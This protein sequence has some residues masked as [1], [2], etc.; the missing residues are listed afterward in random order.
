VIGTLE[1]DWRS[2][3]N[4][5]S[6]IGNWAADAMRAFAE[7]DIAFANSGGFRKDLPAGKITVRDVWEIFPFNNSFV[8]FRVSGKM[9][10]AMISW[11]ADGKGELMQVSGV[12][13]TFDSSKPP[14]QKVVSIEVNANPVDDDKIYSVVTNSYVGGHLHD[15]FGTPERETELSRSDKIDHDLFVDAVKKQKHVSSR[16]EGR[17]VDVAKQ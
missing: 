5:E 17:I 1:V 13:Y 4:H 3:Y 14:G 11:Q 16:V 9:L 15:F 7:T 2:E 6:N 10:R 12:R 8:S